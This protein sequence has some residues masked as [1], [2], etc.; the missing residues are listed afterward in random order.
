MVS[1][2]IVGAV[3][4]LI[5]LFNPWFSGTAFFMMP[6]VHKI[7]NSRFAVDTNKMEVIEDGEIEGEEL[8]EEPQN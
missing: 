2:P 1:L 5:G 6:I 3:A 8:L 7:I 4:V